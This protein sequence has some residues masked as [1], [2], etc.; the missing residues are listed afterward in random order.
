MT[1]AG[2][3]FDVFLPRES[4]FGLVFDLVLL[5]ADDVRLVLLVAVVVVCV[6]C[7]FFKGFGVLSSTLCDI[8]A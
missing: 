4:D 3:V 1:D 8:L 2:L 6:I 7:V 5:L